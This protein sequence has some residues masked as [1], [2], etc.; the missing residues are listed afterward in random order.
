MKM[1]LMLKLQ[2]LMMRKL[3]LLLLTHSKMNLVV[4][5]DGKDM[6]CCYF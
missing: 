5:L 4:V 1:L 6:F 2:E 3:L